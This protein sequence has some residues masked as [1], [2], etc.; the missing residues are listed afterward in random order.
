MVYCPNTQSRPCIDSSL[1]THG[2]SA[3][4]C[5]QANHTL[6]VRPSVRKG[7]HKGGSS[8]LQHNV[9]SVPIKVKTKYWVTCHVFFFRRP[10]Q[11]ILRRHF[12]KI[13]FAQTKRL[14]VSLQN[15]NWTKNIVKLILKNQ[16]HEQAK[17]SQNL[18]LSGTVDK[19]SWYVVLSTSRHRYLSKTFSIHY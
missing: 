6:F 15:M 7:K 17:K 12:V 5:T 13:V 18:A 11:F 3:N 10:E 19:E 1:S 2:Y 16:S 14:T 4:I 9:L 8:F